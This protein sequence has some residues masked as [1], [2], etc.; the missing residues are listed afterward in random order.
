[1]RTVAV[2]FILINIALSNA[3]FLKKT[4]AASFNIINQ[5][6]SYEENAFGR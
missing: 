2:A 3:V 1:M 5:L 4:S 6:K